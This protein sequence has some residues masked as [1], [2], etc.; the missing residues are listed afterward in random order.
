MPRPGWKNDALLAG[1]VAT[2]CLVAMLPGLGRYGLWE[3]WEVERL[4][5]AAGADDSEDPSE[6][7]EEIS[8]DGR[9]DLLAQWLLGSALAGSGSEAQVRLPAALIALS[10]LLVTLFLGA[11]LF[12]WRPAAYSVVVLAGLP[13]FL[14]SSRLLIQSPFPILAFSLVIGGAALTS[15]GPFRG[16]KNAIVGCTAV[17]LGLVIGELSS[18]WFLGRL[19][20]LAGAVFGV[21][22]TKPWK[23][24]TASTVAGILLLIILMGGTAIDLVTRDLSIL[25]LARGGE[26]FTVVIRH[27][28]LGTFP[29][30]GLIIV[31]LGLLFHPRALG[32]RAA[33]A[34]AVLSAGFVFGMVAQTIWNETWSRV[35]FMALWPLSISAGLL[36]DHA[37]RDDTPKKVAAV[38]CGLFMMLGLRD[39]MLEPNVALIAL[40]SESAEFPEG[41]DGKPWLIAIT[42]LLGAPLILALA[43][44]GGGGPEGTNFRGWL[45]RYFGWLFESKGS[46]AVFRWIILAIPALL[47]VHTLLIAFSPPVL[48]FPLFSCIERKIWMAAGLI[49]PFGLFLG[50]LGKLVWGG[51]G[52]LGRMIVPVVLAIGACGALVTVHVILP[53]MSRHF[54]SRGVVLAYDRLRVGEEP[55]LAHRAS[56]RAVELLGTTE[57]EDVGDMDELV[58]RLS[59]REKVF[60]LI[61]AEDLAKV[62]VS[63]RQ[64]TQKHVPVL[65]RSSAT[66]LLLSSE[67]GEGRENLNPLEEI[68]PLERPRPRYPVNANFDDRIELMGIDVEGPGGSETVCSMSS[69]ILRFYWRCLRSVSGNQ[70]IFVHIDGLGQRINGD[71]Y[72]A[73]GDFLTRH[74]REG[75]Y[76][77]D[78]QVLKVP[79]H[80]R[81]GDYTVYVGFFQGSKRLPVKDGPSTSDNR[82]RAGILK[83]R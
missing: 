18:G 80:Y 43:R 16:W 31:G 27:L 33:P 54:S 81:P 28:M 7:S 64:K 5:A 17:A 48:W 77:V 74:W 14:V 55:L 83:V 8:R 4:E 39:H 59:G 78:E 58:S 29:W 79:A 67:F 47:L 50:V 38:V 82:V 42:V 12:G 75:D 26:N 41:V 35:P 73:K 68:V 51:T 25:A 34:A 21:A 69:F 40:G 23:R 11:A 57:V 1:L 36:L 62:D 15:C 13:L 65:D 72:P 45:D 53:S 20:P 19:V 49:V 24:G 61:R 3:P 56:T 44:G 52:R 32:E 63:Y 46:M 30:S 2:F 10:S 71:H 76:I 22:L 6:R 70:K 37:I 60:A 66:T 9:R